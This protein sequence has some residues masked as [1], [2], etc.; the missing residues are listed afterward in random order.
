MT[1]DVEA[2]VQ[3]RRKVYESQPAAYTKG[4][5]IRCYACDGWYTTIIV[6]VE[7]NTIHT[8]CGPYDVKD[9]RKLTEE[10]EQISLF[11]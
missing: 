11:D 10:Y 2:I 3:G 9:I 6:A 4:E 1:Q 5:K 8:A 7:G